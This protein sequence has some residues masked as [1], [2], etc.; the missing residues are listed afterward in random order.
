MA[1]KNTKSVPGQITLAELIDIVGGKSSD[2]IGAMIEQL[3]EA[4]E[5]ARKR[6][7]EER[8]RNGISNDIEEMYS[9]IAGVVGTGAAVEFRTWAKVYKD[10][11]KIEDIFDGKMPP[12]P[13]NNGCYVCAD[14]INDRLCKGAQ[15]RYAAYRQLDTLCGQDAAR[16][17]R[18]ASER[19]YVYRK[20][21]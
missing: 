21:L 9:L 8:R 16:F 3:R 11:P 6:E 20:G 5:Q 17:Q 19:L 15:G 13:K 12:L 4:K 7:E 2:E 18:S 1:C 14:G 10:L